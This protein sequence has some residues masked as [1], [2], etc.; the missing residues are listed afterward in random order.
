MNG[1]DAAANF[2]PEA[3]GGAEG[4]GGIGAAAAEVGVDVGVGVTTCVGMA[5]GAGA[6]LA[7]LLAAGVVVDAEVDAVLGIDVSSLVKYRNPPTPIA[8]RQTSVTAAGHI[9]P[10]GPEA[11][12]LTGFLTCGV[13]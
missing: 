11:C 1:I 10:G 13:A 5:D 9:Q 8:A 6:G 4:A 3:I 2:S 12:A 7:M